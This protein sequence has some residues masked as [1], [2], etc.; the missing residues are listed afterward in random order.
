[1]PVR[2]APLPAAEPGSEVLGGYGGW[3]GGCQGWKRGGAGGEDGQGCVGGDDGL[4]DTAHN[5]TVVKVA[6][7]R[8]EI[9]MHALNAPQRDFALDR[10]TLTRLEPFVEVE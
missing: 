2:E 9:R 3:T 5:H 10:R 1:M 8:A 6:L 7:R 4:I